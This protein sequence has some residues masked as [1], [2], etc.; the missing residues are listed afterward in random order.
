[1]LELCDAVAR[2]VREHDLKART[3]TLKYRDERFETSTRAHTMSE[4]TDSGDVLFREAWRLF[5]RVHGARKVR[6]LGIY[7]S[8][9]GASQLPL[10]GAAASAGRDR[11][12]DA[13]EER[14]GEGSVTRASLLPRPAAFR[15]CDD[16]PPG[17]TASRKGS[18]RLRR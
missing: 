15:G 1:V 17:P 10:F 4:G 7:A 3:V 9:F 13:I 8:G 12:R 14:F 2:R 16:T 18:R 6:L 5:E 11:V